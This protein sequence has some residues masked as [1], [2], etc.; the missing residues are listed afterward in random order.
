MKKK[1]IFFIILTI[2]LSNTIVF[3]DIDTDIKVL[4]EKLNTLSDSEKVDTLN[5]ISELYLDKSSKECLKYAKNALTLSEELKYDKG[6]VDAKNMLGMVYLNTGNFE[7]ASDN[8]SNALTLSEKI[9]YKKANALSLNNLGLLNNL[10]GKYS[11]SLNYFNKALN[12]YQEINDKEG[13]A[14]SFTNIGA[15]QDTLGNSKDALTFYLKALKINEEI[16]N[17]E[18]IA[19]CYNN[20]GYVQN[21]LKNFDDALTYYL[22]ALKINET[23]KN[24][25]GTAIGLNNIAGIYTKLND[26]EQALYYYSKSLN[27]YVNIDNII[28]VANSLN[29]IG[30]VYNELK[31]YTTAIDYYLNALSICEKIEDQ[32]G[33]ISSYNNIGS[34]YYNLDDYEKALTYHLKSLEISKEI[35]FKKGMKISFKNIAYDYEGLKDYKQ[36]FTYHQQYSKLNNLLLEEE[37][38]KSIAEMQTKY[39]TEKKEKEI[40]VL[41]KDNKIKT[42]KY[43]IQKIIS[44]L[45]LIILVIMSIL[46]FII[47]KEKKKSEKLLLNILPVR[48]ANDLK[49]T[50][51]TKPESFENVTVYFSD[52]VGFTKASSTLEPKLLIDELNEIFTQFDNIMEKHKCERIKTIGDAYLAI[53]GLP[54]KNEHHAENMIKASIEILSY[55]NRKNEKSSIKWRIRIGIHSGKVVGGVVGIKKYIYDVFGD[56]INTASRMESNSEPMRINVSQETYEIV[57][58]KF[59]F[60]PR[61]PMNIKGKGLLNMYFIDTKEQNNQLSSIEN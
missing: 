30:S 41:A 44:L 43:T 51:K 6:L 32:Q 37:Q 40:E 29:N 58:E 26:Y 25:E 50:G 19:T 1:L 39:E 47:W 7:E 33:M 60:I 42:L 4:E 57:K 38:M 12:I 56:T 23:I 27:I 15:I 36:A 10:L 55:L 52:I 22:K 21:S 14:Y 18:E 46:G 28:E 3:A 2:L 17:K 54:D 11:E 13:I 48:V 34:I 45:A 53:C 20:I 61:E 59:T 8:F 49:K 16:G 9:Q 5:K 31:E 24:Q 35:D